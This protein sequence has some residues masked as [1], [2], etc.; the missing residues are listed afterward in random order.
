MEFSS[1][2]ED[3]FTFPKISFIDLPKVELFRNKIFNDKKIN[4]KISFSHIFPFYV[5]NIFSHA[6][7]ILMLLV[8]M[9]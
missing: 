7:H 6:F 9:G 5:F 1:C 4:A 3:Y 8:K 2:G